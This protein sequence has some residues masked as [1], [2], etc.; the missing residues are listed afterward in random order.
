[1]D[2]APAEKA[3]Q[4]MQTTRGGLPL[5][6]RKNMSDQQFG[7]RRSKAARK[8]WPEC[9]D[10]VIYRCSHCDG[11]YQG[12]GY[13][14]PMLGPTCCGVSME[15]L[16]PR[17]PADSPSAIAVDY[18]I[19]GGFNQSAVQVFWKTAT[20]ARKPEWVLLKTF[21]GS[22][23]K[24]VTMKKSS[25]V[26]FALADEDAYVYCGRH[27]CQRCSF[28]CKMGFV[29]YIF[30]KDEGLFEMPLEKMAAFFQSANNT[31]EASIEKEKSE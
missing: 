19:V 24:Y 7:P 20:P 28:R 13:E 4:M 10:I 25:P 18:K 31:L 14:A 6:E 23:I 29:A 22:S 21:T 27:V 2:N 15:R 17:D 3:R 1:M 9:P 12:L 16:E 30:F 26:V 11:L 8:P 5:Q